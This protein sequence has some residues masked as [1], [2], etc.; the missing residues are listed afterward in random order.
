[1]QTGIGGLNLP[2]VI[3]SLVACGFVLGVFWGLFWLKRR[4]RE[5]RKERPPQREKLLRPAG[6]SAMRRI[7]ALWEKCMSAVAQAIGAGV[8]FGLAVGTFYPLLAA[9]ALGQVTMGQLWRASGS[10]VILVAAFAA[11]IALLWAVRGFQLVWRLDDELRNWRFGLRGEQAVAEKLADRG[12]AAAGY[13]A[14][15]DVPGEGEWNVDHVVVGP[16]GVFVLETKARPRRKATR[17]QEEQYVFFDGKVLEFPW[18][19]D[20]D[21]AEQ[22]ERNARWVREF[23]A[24]FG[25]KD[26]VVQPVIVVPGWYVESKGNYPVKAMNAKYLV[27]YLKESRQVFSP[28]Q[29]ETTM[30]RLDERCRV[31]EF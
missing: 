4:R 9:L 8:F 30:R 26:L 13:V 5:E 28:E 17:P 10:S 2:Q 24:G 15:H 20:R 11:I 12:V 27:K 22:V 25:P 7:D 23:L 6:Y 14:F 31:V 3:G 1:M 18:C 29:L 19:Y 21:A 16:G